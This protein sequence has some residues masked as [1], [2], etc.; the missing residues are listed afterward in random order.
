MSVAG[1][2][3][4]F[5]WQTAISQS[6]CADETHHSLHRQFYPTV[7]NNFLSVNTRSPKRAGSANGAWWRESEILSGESFKDVGWPHIIS[8]TFPLSAYIL[9]STGHSS[10]QKRC[11]VRTRKP[12]PWFSSI[13]EQFCE[14]KRERRPAERRRLKSKLTIHRYTT[15]LNRK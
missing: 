8:R 1:A 10:P 5:E 11:T 9:P 4:R 7:H 3:K 13:A 14:L 2:G 12:T 15:P 6:A